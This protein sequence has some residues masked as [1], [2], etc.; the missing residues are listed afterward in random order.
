MT[1]TVFTLVTLI[2]IIIIVFIGLF[3]LGRKRT[4]DEKKHREVRCTGLCYYTKTREH[5]GEK[6]ISYITTH[7]RRW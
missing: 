7:R 4:T 5:K 2:I 6:T 3:I 1:T